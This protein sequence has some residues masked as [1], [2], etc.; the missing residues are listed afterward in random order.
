MA[1][2]GSRS[3]WR[4]YRPVHL[5]I[6]FEVPNAEHEQPAVAHVRTLRQVRH[7]SRKG[8]GSRGWQPLPQARLAGLPAP[9]DDPLPLVRPLYAAEPAHALTDRIRNVLRCRL[10]APAGPARAGV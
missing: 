1:T 5:L 2:L 8:S 3:V 6:G 10:L 7:T 4:G 9:F